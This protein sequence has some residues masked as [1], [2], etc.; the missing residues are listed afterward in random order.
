[1]IKFKIKNILYKK[2]YYS[3]IERWCIYSMDMAKNNYPIHQLTFLSEGKYAKVYLLSEDKVIK[4]IK[5]KYFYKENFDKLHK[6]IYF[7]KKMK[8]ISFVPKMYDYGLDYIVMDYIKGETLFD[9]FFKRKKITKKD[10]LIINNM[11]HELEKKE[12]YHNDTHFQN[13][14]YSNNKYFLIDFGNADEKPLK[15][16]WKTIN[17]LFPLYLYI[18]YP[19]RFI[20]LNNY[21]KKIYF[22]L[23]YKVIN[24]FFKLNR[25]K[26]G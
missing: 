1:M 12:I 15:E 26:K 3:F 25:K 19:L 18:V 20:L 23:K 4:I 8:D 9:L 22:F 5:E 16:K 24:Y 6:E 11:L 13:I 14:I 10:M 17:K 2:E 7:Y 21:T